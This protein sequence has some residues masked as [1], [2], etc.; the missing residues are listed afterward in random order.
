MNLFEEIDRYKEDLPKINNIAKEVKKQK[1]NVYQIVACITM[2]ISFFA[3]LILGNLFPSCGST[4]TIYD[5]T[6]CVDTEFNIS[7]TLFFWF[8]SFLLCLFFYG[9]GHIISLLT[10]IDKKLS[11][12]HSKNNKT[13]K[14]KG[15]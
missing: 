2:I 5:T 11:N 4:A 6:S 14:Y 15:K 12:K 3:G 10:S 7:L 8:S 13:H 1:L 9:M